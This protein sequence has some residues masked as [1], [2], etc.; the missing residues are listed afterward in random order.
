MRTSLALILFVSVGCTGT[1]S[2][3]GGRDSGVGGGEDSGTV[4]ALDGANP[5]VDGGPVVIPGEPRG[6]ARVFFSGH[7]LI[8]V[9]TPTFFEQ[10]ATRN[11]RDVDYQLQMGLGSTLS[12][13]LACP[14]NGQQAD[15]S[16]LTFRVADE[17]RSGRYDTLMFTERHDIVQ[18]IAYERT[19]SMARRLRDAFYEGSPGGRV[20]FFESWLTIDVARP[21][22]F[23]ERTRRDA[24]GWECVASRLNESRGS[25]PPLLVVP[26]ARALAELVED[27]MAG[28]AA[29]L[30]NLRQ[31]FTD[32][33]HLTNEGNYFISL[34]H[35]GVVL[36]ES[37]I[38]LSAS[39]LRPIADPPPS[40][41]DA[42]ASYLQGLAARWVERT[43]AEA[44]ASQRARSECGAAVRSL[45]VDTLGAGDWA[46]SQIESAW[47]DDSAAVPTINEPWCRR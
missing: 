39:G 24:I 17:L 27:V 41:D 26:A 16:A 22:G 46:C 28:R 21:S 45:C 15:G 14:L 1:T 29:G 8:N 23:V 6:D 13:R 33:V 31:I 42:S 44:A 4:G 5:A 47:A 2:G 25:H 9:N 43:F 32:D 36:Q 34:L 37:P 18:T 3:S 38:G 19:T 35:Y 7:S 11:G 40:L 10:L 12:I 30:T 20:F